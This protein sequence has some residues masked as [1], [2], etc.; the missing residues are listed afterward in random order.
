MAKQGYIKLYRQIQDSWIWRNHE[1]A[2]AWIDLLLLAEHAEHKRIYKGELKIYARGTV[3]LSISALAER[4]G[5]TWKK[6]KSFLKALEKDEMCQLNV[7]TNDTTI[8][9]VNYS[10]F[11]EQGERKTERVTERVTE[12]GQSECHISKNDKN[13]K[14]VNRASGRKTTFA[15]RMAERNAIME[16]IIREAEEEERR[17]QEEG[18]E[19]EDLDTDG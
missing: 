17:K 16:R 7:T 11:Q 1:Y 8:A 13:D 15:E 6:T 14:N 12:R 4:W 9:L 10:L 2:Y 5:W 19:D 3:N 18:Y